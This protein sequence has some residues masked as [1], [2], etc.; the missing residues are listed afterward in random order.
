MNLYMIRYTCVKSTG[1]LINTFD[2]VVAENSNEALLFFKL[3]ELIRNDKR[4]DKLMLSF[5]DSIEIIERLG[6]EN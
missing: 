1:A 6:K 4:E 5:I 2:Y 3:H